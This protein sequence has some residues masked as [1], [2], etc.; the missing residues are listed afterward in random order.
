MA[1]C[2]L[3]SAIVTLIAVRAP[4]KR[5]EPTALGVGAA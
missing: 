2:A 3:I 4:Q 5:V 1:G